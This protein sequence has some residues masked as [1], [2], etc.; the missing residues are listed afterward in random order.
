MKTTITAA[1][2]FI[3]YIHCPA[4]NTPGET[5]GK[6]DSITQNSPLQLKLG[7]WNDN[8]FIEKLGGEEV[9]LGSDDNVTASFW[10]QISR[11][12]RED[13]WFLDIYH[14]I[15]THKDANYRVDLLTARISCENLTAWGP[16]KLGGG[17]ISAGNFGGESIQNWYHRIRGLPAL[18]LPYK[19][20]GDVNLI[21]YLNFKP[22]L[23]EARCLKINGYASN[24]LRTGIGPGNYQT[25]LQFN[26]FTNTLKDKG[27]LHLQV[28]TGYIHYYLEGKYLSPLFDHG[29]TWGT[30]LS[31]GIIGKINSSVWFTSN[32]Y[33]LKQPHFGFSLTL[34]WDGTRMSDLNDIAFP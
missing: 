9:N 19:R 23:W 30:L 33:G 12:C 21:V 26:C 11:K 28:G 5:G 24:S 17:V 29:F 18:K 31:L 3:V 6:N 13:W 14:N 15:L 32:Q 25:G 10:L 8:V 2:L 1:F 27:L 34:G 7:Y 16:L 22:R 20:Y 4:A